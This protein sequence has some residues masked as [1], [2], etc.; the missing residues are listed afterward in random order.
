M[1]DDSLQLDINLQSRDTSAPS[2]F[3]D[4]ARVDKEWRDQTSPW[5]GARWEDGCCPEDQVIRS[6]KDVIRQFAR[7]KTGPQKAKD[8]IVHPVLNPNTAVFPQAARIA[9]R[10]VDH[11][12]PPIGPSKIGGPEKIDQGIVLIPQAAWL[13]KE[14]PGGIWIAAV[15]GNHMHTTYTFQAGYT[16]DG[17]LDYAYD[18]PTF[19]NL[20]AL[21]GE[22]TKDALKKNDPFGM[23]TATDPDTM[24]P[25]NVGPWTGYG[26][27]AGNAHIDLTMSFQSEIP[28]GQDPLTYKPNSPPDPPLAPQIFPVGNGIQ[29]FGVISLPFDTDIS[30]LTL[31]DFPDLPLSQQWKIIEIHQFKGPAPTALPDVGVV[32]VLVQGVIPDGMTSLDFM[33]SGNISVSLFAF[34]GAKSNIKLIQGTIARFNGEITDPI[35]LKQIVLTH[36]IGN[37]DPKQYIYA[38]G[39]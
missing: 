10:P 5:T 11:S 16:V 19:G 18:Q 20:E 31:P 30:M 39:G 38:E 21:I 6:G 3:S 26:N 4:L 37:S 32:G 33:A 1:P 22:Q 13:V 8:R 14:K 17:G 23:G 15:A 36:P 29:A 24:L 7:V 25:V 35:P 34:Q 12:Q 28:D 9:G 2:W 27:G